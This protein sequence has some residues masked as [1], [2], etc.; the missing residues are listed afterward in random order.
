[1]KKLLLL[2]LLPAFFM[3]A[4]IKSKDLEIRDVKLGDWTPDI[5]APIINTTLTLKNVVKEGDYVSTD[6]TGLYSLHYQGKLFSVAAADYIKLPDQH[7][8]VTPFTLTT[9][10][11]I[12][13]FTGSISDSFASSFSYTDTNGAGLEHIII[14]T[15]SLQIT[16]TNTFNQNISLTA[17]FPDIRKNGVRLSVP[18]NIN[19]PSTSTSV[20]IDLSGYTIDLSKGGTSRNYIPYKF[21]YTLSGSGQPIATSNTIS[22]SVNLTN[23]NFGFIDGYLGRYNFSVPW[24]TIGINIFRNT[25]NSSIFLEDPKVNLFFT[26]SFGVGVSANFDSVYGITPNNTKIRT[27]FPPL[28]VTGASTPGAAASS[29]YTVNKTNST[30]QNIFN[31]APDKVIYKGSMQVNSSSGSGYAFVLDTSRITINADA[32]LPAFLKIITFSLQDTTHLKLPNDTDLLDR[33]DFKMVVTNRF[34]VYGNIQLYFADETYHIIDSLVQSGGGV[35]GQAPVDANG[36]VNGETTAVST[37]TFQ[38]DRYKHMAASVKYVFTRGN[39]YSSGNNS[40]K[41]FNTDNVQ[42]RIGVRFKLKVKTTD[43]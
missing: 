31:P 14:K 6:G 30:I 25:L 41:I 7:F 10:V 42:I 40:V 39:L 11:S 2:S 19:Y 21:I 20:N 15:A 26:N 13:S 38:H 3:A 29:S 33:A 17:V 27:V 22:A 28:S 24:D 34:P 36:K 35:I 16:F 8:N 37:F 12:P 43:L 9:P 4:C 1:M 32:E 23:L 18:V 5:A